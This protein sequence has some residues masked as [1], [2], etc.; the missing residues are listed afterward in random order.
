M[1]RSPRRMERHAN[2]RVITVL[3]QFIAAFRQTYTPKITTQTFFECQGYSLQFGVQKYAEYDKVQLL[4]LFFPVIPT[5][6]TH[7]DTQ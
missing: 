3:R 5:V 6:V 4:L 7:L 2:L 1:L